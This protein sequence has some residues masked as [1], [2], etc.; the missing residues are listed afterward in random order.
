[1]NSTFAAFIKMI[2]QWFKLV[3]EITLKIMK[4]VNYWS[5]SVPKIK[6][7]RIGLNYVLCSKRTNYTKLCNLCNFKMAPGCKIECNILLGICIK[8]VDSG[9][10]INISN[11][12]FRCLKID[13][14]KGDGTIGGSSGIMLCIHLT[15][16]RNTIFNYP[17]VPSKHLVC[18]ENDTQ[19]DNLTTSTVL[20]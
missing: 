2:K 11:K 7:V 1:M 14:L 19:I 3:Y 8:F 18:Y 9:H 6:Y 4:I 15:M 10:V 5:F 13:I 17:F 20:N 12:M 16:C